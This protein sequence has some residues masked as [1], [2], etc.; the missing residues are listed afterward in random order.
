MALAWES[1]GR[2]ES[3]IRFNVP[4]SRWGSVP[5]SLFLDVSL[6]Y[7]PGYLMVYLVVTGGG[8]N[9]CVILMHLPR[10]RGLSLGSGHASSRVGVVGGAVGC[11]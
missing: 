2:V 9:L 10:W 4:S 7:F 8:V 1:Q 11:A 6:S 3:L 5:H